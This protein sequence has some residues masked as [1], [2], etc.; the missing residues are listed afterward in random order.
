MQQSI[1]HACTW[2]C[3]LDRLKLLQSLDISSSVCS[4]YC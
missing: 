2:N 1:T 3:E 4:D